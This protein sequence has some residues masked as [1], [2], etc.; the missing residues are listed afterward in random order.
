MTWVQCVQEYCSL[1]VVASDTM[2][3]PVLSIVSIEYQLVVFRRLNLTQLQ[4][5]SIV[6]LVK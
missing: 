6:I 1:W 2:Q 4:F 3:Y 5:L